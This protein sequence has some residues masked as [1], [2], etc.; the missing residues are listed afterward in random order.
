ME[1]P[2][3]QAR[4]HAPFLKALALVVLLGMSYWTAYPPLLQS[5]QSLCPEEFTDEC[6][7]SAACSPVVSIGFIE[8]ISGYLSDYDDE[9]AEAEECDAG[10]SGAL[11]AID[12]QQAF[13]VSN[14]GTCN[15]GG[16]AHFP[17]GDDNIYVDGSLNTTEQ[18][19]RFWHEGWSRHH[20]CLDY[21]CHDHGIMH[22]HMEE[23]YGWVP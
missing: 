16:G 10:R 19:K 2:V 23:C 8:V 11:D 3:Q 20:G 15:F 12:E 21:I 1:T 22:G 9:Y 18:A 17:G 6:G 4:D 14:W 7:A 5:A 13:H